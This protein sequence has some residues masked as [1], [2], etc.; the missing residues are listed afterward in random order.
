M[1]LCVDYSWESG[2][3]SHLRVA[4]LDVA[5]LLRLLKDLRLL[6][7]VLA[8]LI[9]VVGLLEIFAVGIQNF[10]IIVRNISC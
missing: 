6:V 5:L 4:L 10:L 2:L 9:V 8:L 1:V 7:I 3:L